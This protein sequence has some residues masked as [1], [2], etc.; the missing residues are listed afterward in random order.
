M[1]F[2]PN[3]HRHQS[4][5]VHGYIFM[6][7]KENKDTSINWRCQN[8]RNVGK[9]RCAVT[10]TT[11]NGKITRRPPEQHIVDGWL[12]HEPP[13][14]GK[15]DAM[16]CLDG[17]KTEVKQTMHPLKQLYEKSVNKFLVKE[18]VDLAKFIDFA[19]ECP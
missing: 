19:I 7:A 17:I 14:Q 13:T 1:E 12:I 6:K 2:V 16:Q 9:E 4:L 10:C 5:V 8:S 3:T 15:K 11:L 18:N